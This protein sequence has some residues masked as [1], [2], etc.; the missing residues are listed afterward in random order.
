MWNAT[1]TPKF[2]QLSIFDDVGIGARC[3]MKNTCRGTRFRPRPLA[4]GACRML[5][6]LGIRILVGLVTFHPRTLPSLANP[7]FGRGTESPTDTHQKS[8]GS[9]TSLILVG[10]DR[11]ILSLMPMTLPRFRMAAAFHPAMRKPLLQAGFIHLRN[12]SEPLPLFLLFAKLTPVGTSEM[13][14][15]PTAA[16]EVGT[17][18][19][20]P[21]RRKKRRDMLAANPMKTPA[22]WFQT[23]SSS[24]PAMKVVLVDAEAL[25]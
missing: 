5:V 23:L 25:D 7:T 20:P 17:V 6:H 16:R 21:L 15:L 1:Y 24:S 18:K 22:G 11:R 9:H 2:A 12:R 3:L 19:K 4:K 10:C 13:I 8:A 14:N